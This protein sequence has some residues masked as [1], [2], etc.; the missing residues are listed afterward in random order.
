MNNYVNF[1]MSSLTPTPRRPPLNKISSQLIPLPIIAPLRYVPSR[2]SHVINKHPIPLSYLYNCSRYVHRS[3][4]LNSIIPMPYQN[5]L[6]RPHTHRERTS[7][8]N[9]NTLNPNH[10]NSP[11]TPIPNEYDSL[12]QVA[13][14]TNKKITTYLNS[15]T[16]QLNTITTHHINEI[17]I[18]ST[19]MSIYSTNEGFIKNTMK[20]ILL[21]SIGINMTRDQYAKWYYKVQSAYLRDSKSIKRLYAREMGNLLNNKYKRSFPDLPDP[22]IPSNLPNP[23]KI[24][25][26]NQL[27]H[28]FPSISIIGDGNGGHF[29]FTDRNNQTHTIP[30]IEWTSETFRYITITEDI[31]MNS[32]NF[33]IY[34]KYSQYYT[35]KLSSHSAEFFSTE[36]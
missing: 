17:I 23:Y 30:F 1:K 21:R 10:L 26:R 3:T 34:D 32:L 36:L 29:Q 11:N 15:F 8:M 25:L 4:Y 7:Q 9:T 14:D 20:D 28:D 19:A 6:I 27:A 5:T 13:I 2:S 31:V 24:Q 12:L 35:F 18:K 16:R 22:L 33:Y